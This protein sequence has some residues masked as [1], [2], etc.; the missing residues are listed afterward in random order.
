VIDHISSDH[1]AKQE[2]PIFADPVF[3]DIANTM[4]QAV[5]LRE[6][7][8][9]SLASQI[10]AYQSRLPVCQRERPLHQGWSVRSLQLTGRVDAAFHDPL[11]RSIRTQLLA[12]GGVRHPFQGVP[13]VL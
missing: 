2:V 3:T 8:R 1:L 13:S 4:G 12:L 7:A 11:V 6:E 10:D 9:L 5:R